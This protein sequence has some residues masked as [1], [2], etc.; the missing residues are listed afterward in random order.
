MGSNGSGVLYDYDAGGLVIDDTYAMIYI[1]EDPESIDQ[2]VV[3][4]NGKTWEYTGKTTIVTEYVRRR[5][6]Q[7]G[8]EPHPDHEVQSYTSFPEVLGHFTY[9]DESGSWSSTYI[10]NTATKSRKSRSLNS[11][12]RT[13]RIK[14]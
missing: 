14:K 10:T 6:G 4:V 3:D 1:R 8:Q 2:K 12:W 7:P 11:W 13:M 9:Y 5:D